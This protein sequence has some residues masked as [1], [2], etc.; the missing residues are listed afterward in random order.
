FFTDGGCMFRRTKLLVIASLAIGGLL[1]YLAASGKLNLLHRAEAGPPVVPAAALAVGEADNEQVIV[2]EVLLP[3]N[4]VLEIDGNKTTE[5]GGERT[6]QTP[7]LKVGGRYNYTLKATS[8]DKVVTRQVHLSH[9]A[10]NSFDLRPDF[11]A[12]GASKAKPTALTQKPG[13]S[14]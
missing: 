13:D 12:A 8:G 7:P 2:F 14:Q 3:G 10:A 4:A 9:G 11:Q 6:Y 1:G 5:T